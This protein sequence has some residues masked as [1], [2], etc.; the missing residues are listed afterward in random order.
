MEASNGTPL[1]ERPLHDSSSMH[2]SDPLTAGVDVVFVESGS[3]TDILV[4]S[5]SMDVRRLHGD[6]GAVKWQWKA[7]D[8][9]YVTSDGSRASSSIA[10]ILLHRSLNMH[11]QLAVSGSRIYVVSFSKSFSSYTLHITILDSVSGRQLSSNHVPSTLKAGLEDIVVLSPSSLSSSPHLLWVESGGT[12][13]GLD[14]PPDGVVT[15][16]LT[17][18]GARGISRIIDIGQSHNGYVL[19]EGDDRTI[20]VLKFDAPGTV[21][22]LLIP[23]LVLLIWFILDILLPLA[24]SRGLLFHQAN[25]C[26]HYRQ[27]LMVVLRCCTLRKGREAM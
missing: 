9:G 7:S 1:W 22:S 8:E 27:M 20:L 21:L 10:G 11:I 26:I 16:P 3:A 13:K 6:T 15:K 4:L 12:I 23:D 17:V 24:F 2:L 19:A 14:L 5:N 18:K 25:L